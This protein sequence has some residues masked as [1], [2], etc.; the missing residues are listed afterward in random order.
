[1]AKI[2]GSQQQIL[3]C[4]SIKTRPRVSIP[5]KRKTTLFVITYME[6]I[7]TEKQQLKRRCTRNQGIDRKHPLR[8]LEIH[9]G[10]YVRAECLRASGGVRKRLETSYQNATSY[11][12]F[13]R[14]KYITKKEFPLPFFS[15][16][17]KI[18]S[19]SPKTSG[20]RP[21]LLHPI[22]PIRNRGILKTEQKRPF[23]S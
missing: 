21:S 14:N 5:I 7:S 20:L 2:Y 4:R 3:P 18:K 22:F 12:L 10:R 19:P 23:F 16:L 1:L 17:H 11:L 6:A 8:S 9:F 15:F 13:A